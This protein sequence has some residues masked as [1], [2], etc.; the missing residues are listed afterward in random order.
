VKS[1]GK[2][3]ELDPDVIRMLD[4]RRIIAQGPNAP[5]VALR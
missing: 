1:W 4:Q 2:D 5:Q 3:F